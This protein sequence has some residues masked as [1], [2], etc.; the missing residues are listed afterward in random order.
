MV[1]VKAIVLTVKLVLLT[2]LIS[3][4]ATT[5]ELF[6]EYDDS[7][8]L[9][10][11]S[12]GAEKSDLKLSSESEPNQRLNTRSNSQNTESELTT[13]PVQTPKP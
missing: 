2:S 7:F 1:D 13:Q 11:E 4:C 9:S 6:P 12:T 3:S 8:C 10:F 5:E